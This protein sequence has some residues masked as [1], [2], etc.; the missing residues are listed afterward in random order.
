M[1]YLLAYW[2]G[3]AK[4]RLHTEDTLAILDNIT[5]SLGISLR[6]F[7][8]D[9]CSIYK[10]R[11]LPSE[12]A[13]RSR[14]EA[15]RQQ[16]PR[17]PANLATIPGESNCPITSNNPWSSNSTAQK[18]KGKEILHGVTAPMSRNISKNIIHIWDSH[19]LYTPAAEIGVEV[20]K[21]EAASAPQ[22]SRKPRDFNLNTYKLHSL[23]DYTDTIRQYGSTDSYS[24]QLVSRAWMPLWDGS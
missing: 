1:L 23:G 18:G 2:Q 19:H 16:K 21:V 13:S 11:E 3:L 17:H 6:A 12:A 4:L 14:R 9:T 7:K 10:T 5:R 24:T 22:Y 20:S 8:K 15:R